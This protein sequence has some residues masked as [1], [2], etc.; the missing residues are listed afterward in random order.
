[1][2]R[3][4]LGFTLIELLVV[5]AII[6]VLI[7]LLLP[8][9]QQAR[10]AARRAQC[11]NNLKQIGLACANYVDGHGTLPPS[12]FIGMDF[13]ALSYLL[14]Y[15]DATQLYESINY[16]VPAPAPGVPPVNHPANDTVRNTVVATFL[17]P[18]DDKNRH[19][20]DGAPVNYW[21]NKGMDI[22]WFLPNWPPMPPVNTSFPQ[23]NGVF[24][25]N[26]KIKYKDLLDGT[27]K[28][29]FFSERLQR[30]G[31]NGI[32]SMP[33]DI[34]LSTDS[35]TTPDEA[36][37]MCNAVDK[38]NL[39]NQFPFEM[40]SPW[41]HGQHAYTH[42][43]SPNQ[44]SCGFLFVLRQT[45]PPSSRHPG[46]VNVL[47]GDGSVTMISNTIDIMCWRALGTR[48]GGENCHDF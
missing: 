24:F 13:S 22:V 48:D 47:F 31:S 4:R 9:I 46:G 11:Q 7:A 41:L 45:M 27:S 36:V 33:E 15:V 3:R 44:P 5:I 43:S 16:E 23:P 28:T 40:G 21:V 34:F 39:A 35:P 10:E 1:M 25:H 17:C 2:S 20:A 26:S 18:D 29:A 12:R 6:G 42:I 14:P 32:S 19:P 37:D 38:S 8:A 30:D